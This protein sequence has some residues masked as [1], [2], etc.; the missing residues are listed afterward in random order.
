MSFAREREKNFPRVF[1]SDLEK[2]TSE[3]HINSI[4]RNIGNALQI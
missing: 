4:V 2:T 3:V 1:F